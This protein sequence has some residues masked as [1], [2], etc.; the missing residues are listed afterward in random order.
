MPTDGEDATSN[1]NDSQ[2]AAERALEAIKDEFNKMTEP[3]DATF[4]VVTNEIGSGTHSDHAM[5]RQFV[6]AQ[7]WLNQFVATKAD[8][9]IHMVCG[10]ASILKTSL[11]DSNA[12]NNNPLAAPNPQAVNEAAMLDKF[13]SARTLPMDP[14]GYFMIAVDHSAT[15]IVVKFYS[16]ILNDD[17]E[18]CDLEGNKIPCH[19]TN[20]A[21]PM[22]VWKGRTAKEVTVK[23][24]EQWE[25][26]SNVVTVGHAAYIGREVQRAQDC[27]YSGTF[28]QQ[29]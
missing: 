3:W 21:E 14:K 26:A 6:D 9:V 8:Q 17:G 10:Q 19:G 28:Y 25:H 29:D 7:G 23:I 12:N 2:Q 15:K 5:T 4:V 18:V 16:C 11:D 22:M 13:L 24:F 1:T 20:R 27:L